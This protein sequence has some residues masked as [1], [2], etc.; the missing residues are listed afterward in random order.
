MVRK[1]WLEVEIKTGAFVNKVWNF[2][3]VTETFLPTS[4][5]A[6]APILLQTDHMKFLLCFRWSFCIQVSQLQQFFV[7]RSYV[8]DLLSLHV[9]FESVNYI[10]MLQYSKKAIVKLYGITINHV[11]FL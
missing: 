6:D 1:N 9:L 5:L 8:N 7:G 4:L 3:R 2:F 10:F 11:N